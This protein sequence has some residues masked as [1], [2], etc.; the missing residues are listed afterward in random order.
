MLHRLRSRVW[1][2]CFIQDFPNLTAQAQQLHESLLYLLVCLH[3]WK[4]GRAAQYQKHSSNRQTSLNNIPAMSWFQEPSHSIWQHA[5]SPSSNG[6]SPNFMFIS[7]VLPNTHVLL[8]TM[9][10]M[11]YQQFGWLGTSTKNLLD[12]ISAK[13]TSTPHRELFLHSG[14]FM[15]A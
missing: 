3:M 2:F 14:W 7:T 8:Q 13:M 5:T 6:F 12:I 1:F 11:G 9:G 10:S 15:V 4:W